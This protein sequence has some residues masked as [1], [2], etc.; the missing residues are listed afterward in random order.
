[1]I[2]Q[3]LSVDYPSRVWSLYENSIAKAKI[4][5]HDVSLLLTVAMPL[6]VILSRQLPESTRSRKAS[7]SASSAGTCRVITSKMIDGSMAK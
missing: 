6:I 3:R 4:D 1:V 5:G 7:A 2:P